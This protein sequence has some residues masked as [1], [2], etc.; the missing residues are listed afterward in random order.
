[1][2]SPVRRPVLVE[3]SSSE[4]GRSVVRDS[5]KTARPCVGSLQR[6]PWAVASWKAWAMLS[7]SV[8]EDLGIVLVVEISSWRLERKR[9]C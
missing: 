5:R 9:C 4:A 8:E 7:A 1:M 6:G 3:D 2:I